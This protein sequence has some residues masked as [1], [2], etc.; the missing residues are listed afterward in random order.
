[1]LWT[2]HQIACGGLIALNGPSQ[3]SSNH[4]FA[5]Y[6]CSSRQHTLH[7]ALGW[8]YFS[9]ICFAL[10][11]IWLVTSPLWSLHAPAAAFI[12]AKCAFHVQMEMLCLHL[13]WICICS[14]RHQY[15][16]QV[17]LS[18]FSNHCYSFKQSLLSCWSVVPSAVSSMTTRFIFSRPH[19]GMLDPVYSTVRDI[20]LPEAKISTDIPTVTFL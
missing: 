19:S 2:G 7:F 15:S 17:F 10:H 14:I 5:G 16:T 12:R 11:F 1:M 4:S 20:N 9:C 18:P 6:M 13:S 3:E 8:N